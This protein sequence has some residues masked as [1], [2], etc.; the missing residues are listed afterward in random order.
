M[1]DNLSNII[2][3]QNKIITTPI[4]NNVNID[5]EKSKNQLSEDKEIV[6][7]RKESVDKNESLVDKEESLVDKEESE[8]KEQNEVR[9]DDIEQD[10]VKLIIQDDIK[11]TNKENDLSTKIPK[12]TVDNIKSLNIYNLI[13]IFWKI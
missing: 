12:E 11:E 2:E 4:K 7:N 13:L 8:L 6:I 9:N 1:K 5:I 10:N 3:E